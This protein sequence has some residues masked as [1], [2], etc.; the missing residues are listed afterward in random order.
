MKTL[1]AMLV[2]LG[3]LAAVVPAMAFENDNDRS[4]RDGARSFY[5]KLDS[6]RGG[7]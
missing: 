6:E 4:V 1:I 5:D 7:D 2:A 3:T